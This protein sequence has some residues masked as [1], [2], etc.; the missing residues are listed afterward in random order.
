LIAWRVATIAQ[1]ALWIVLVLFG[2]QLTF[3]AIDDHAPIWETI[4]GFGGFGSVA[5]MWTKLSRVLFAANIVG[6]VLY[7]VLASRA[8][9]IPEERAAGIYAV[10]GEPFIWALSVFPIWGL[11]LIINLAWA[12]FVIRGARWRTGL[13]WLLTLSIWI[14]GAAID[15]YHH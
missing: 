14:A 2:L 8:W 10:T 11:F 1:W 12:A 4:A 13:V 3:I 5:S 6:V 9:A 7:D 15:F